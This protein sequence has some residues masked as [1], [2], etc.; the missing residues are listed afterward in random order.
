M[1]RDSTIE[2]TDHINRFEYNDPQKRKVLALVGNG[3]LLI[4]L[5]FVAWVKGELFCLR[6]EPLYRRVEPYSSLVVWKDGTVS[7][8]DLYFRAKRVKLDHPE[9]GQD[10]TDNI[11][12]TTYGQR[13]MSRK[14]GFISPSKIQEQYYE[15]EH[16]ILLPFISD[17]K[18]YLWLSHLEKNIEQKK[19]A[20]VNK[21]VQ[22]KIEISK[23]DTIK[24]LNEKGYR[25][26]GAKS[27]ELQGEYQINGDKIS[28][29]FKSGLF[30]HNI[31]AT[32]VDKKVVSI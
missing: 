29:V 31:I 11:I 7:I 27:P 3:N 5:W 32:T 16:L 6:D 21:P 8:E 22:L 13:L 1:M 20:L 14:Y 24:L 2:F 12:Y 10:V 17:E 28:V 30:P 23:E 9:A 15:S 4:N 26:S 19:Y 18:G 25:D